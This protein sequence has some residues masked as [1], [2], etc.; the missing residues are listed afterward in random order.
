M[1]VEKNIE[2]IDIEKLKPYK[3]NPKEHDKIK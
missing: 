2:V 1:E 3:N